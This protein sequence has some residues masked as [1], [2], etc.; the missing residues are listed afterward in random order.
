MK[1]IRVHMSASNYLRYPAEQLTC[2]FMLTTGVN[3]HRPAA[4]WV[5]TTTFFSLSCSSC[6]MAV[7]L[8]S[9]DFPP[10]RSHSSHPPTLHYYCESISGT[11]PP[12]PSLRP[13]H[14]QST[15]FPHAPDRHLGSSPVDPVSALCTLHSALCSL[16]SRRAPRVPVQR[17]P[18]SHLRRPCIFLSLSCALWTLMICQ[19]RAVHTVIGDQT[20]RSRRPLSD[21]GRIHTP[22]RPSPAPRRLF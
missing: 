10:T 4:I 17:G 20:A 13:S 7:L 5:H 3:E 12:P 6:C 15:A 14:L 18:P 11:N 21:L 19:G 2:S 1:I 16:P 8:P 22:S 9:P